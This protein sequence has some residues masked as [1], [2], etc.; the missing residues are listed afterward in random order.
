MLIDW[1]TVG[2]QVVN[3]LVLAWLLK[4]FLYRPI[5]DAIDAREKRIAAELADADARKAEARKERDDFQHRNETFDQERA[6]LLKKA[7]EEAKAERQR[8]LAEA[9]KEAE[10]LRAKR[11]EALRTEQRNLNRDIIQ[12]TQKEV[13]AV[14]RQTLADLASASLEQRMS[15]EFIQRLRAL[16]GADKTQ[17]AG[18]LHASSTPARV[19]SAFDL[20]VEQHAAIQKALNETL[21]ADIPLQFET[22]PELVCGIELAANGQKVAWSIAEHLA[23]L[24]KSAAEILREDA[25]P[26]PEPA[27]PAAKGDH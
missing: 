27:A 8:L 17:L 16:D 21:S 1:F 11:L 23:T 15:E 2:A 24:E 20:P 3:F 12:R 9:R 26:V 5:L 7:T 22:A 25:P 10:T 14:A 4:R 13:F 18:A 19:R 6:A